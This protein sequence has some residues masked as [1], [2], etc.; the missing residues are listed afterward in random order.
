M[1][2]NLWKVVELSGSTKK[3]K[4]MQKKVLTIDGTCDNIIKRS[5]ERA[6]REA[7]RP[8]KKRIAKRFFEADTKKLQ[9]SLKKVLTKRTRCAKIN[10]L[11]PRQRRTLKIEQHD[12]LQI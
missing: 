12:S 7:D 10:K 2:E 11:S 1:L 4:K 5:G 8:P 3:T 6:K 9:K